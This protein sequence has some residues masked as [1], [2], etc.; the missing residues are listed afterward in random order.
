M[1]LLQI[2][3]SRKGRLHEQHVFVKRPGLFLK[4]SSFNGEK[5]GEQEKTSETE[6]ERERCASE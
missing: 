3:R 6:R 1:S 2:S 5:A 4:T